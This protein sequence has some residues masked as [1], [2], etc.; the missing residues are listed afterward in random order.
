MYSSWID[1]KIR[2]RNHVAFQLTYI[3]AIWERFACGYFI[4]LFLSSLMLSSGSHRPF[5]TSSRL[6]LSILSHSSLLCLR[7][8]HCSFRAY[9]TCLS[10]ASIFS[11]F[12]IQFCSTFL[13]IVFCLVDVLSLFVLL[14]TPNKH[15]C[16]M[17]LS[18]V[19]VFRQTYYIVMTFLLQRHCC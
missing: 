19:D 13:V 9:N 1:F 16:L 15:Q 17:L 14:L 4:T 11:C 2:E 18:L 6:S 3:E 5:S 10:S 12:S 8:F 7:T